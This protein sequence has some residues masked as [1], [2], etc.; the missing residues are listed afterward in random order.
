MYSNCTSI[1]F[2]KRTV[3]FGILLHI[4][5]MQGCLGYLGT[6]DAVQDRNR[7]RQNLVPKLVGLL[8]FTQFINQAQMK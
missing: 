1:P 7:P 6:A 8:R 4:G 5:A 3:N 2:R